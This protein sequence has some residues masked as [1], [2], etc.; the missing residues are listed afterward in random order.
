MKSLLLF[1]ST[2][3]ISANVYADNYSWG[4]EKPKKNTT[5]NG[6]TIYN[7]FIEVGG[8][9]EQSPQWSGECKNGLVSGWG[10]IRPSRY[11]SKMFA[12]FK[13]GRLV[14]DVFLYIF[15]EDSTFFAYKSKGV[16]KRGFT[17]AIGDCKANPTHGQSC[18][19]IMAA[20]KKTNPYP[21]VKTKE[22]C[23]VIDSTRILKRHKNPSWTGKCINGLGS[24]LGWLTFED[25]V[26]DT[27][28]YYKLLLELK[29][30][31]LSNKYF[32]L[33]NTG[34]GG[35]EKSTMKI[36][37]G[38]G[39]HSYASCDKNP[40]C[41]RIENA[42]KYGIPGQQ[43]PP[44]VPSSSRYDSGS[45]GN[46]SGS[47]ANTFEA[48]RSYLKGYEGPLTACTDQAIDAAVEQIRPR[49]NFNTQGI[50]D[51]AKENAKLMYFMTTLIQKSCPYDQD[52]ISAY[53]ESFRQS[54]ELEEGSCVY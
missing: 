34:Y 11:L 18:A 32:H 14:S 3:L 52:K 17:A 16:F 41:L 10:Y 44:L 40:E 50:C 8:D 53:D 33:N 15:D 29:E 5:T 25:T 35:L 7:P 28:K 22:G 39:L 45:N 37:E 13:E 48:P 30:G 54:L 12:E 21:E 1:L 24:G 9:D 19:R 27:T 36:N 51:S 20:L 47:R 38:Y 42:E 2:I 46:V 43:K 23:T 26:N 6:C 31:K 49:L 4:F